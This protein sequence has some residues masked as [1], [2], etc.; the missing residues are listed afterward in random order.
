MKII[1]T[2]IFAFSIF[3]SPVATAQPHE[4]WK[5]CETAADCV[6][7]KA[8][9]GVTAVHKQYLKDAEIYWE[10]TAP[11]VECSAPTPNDLSI[12]KPSC[13]HQKTTCIK[14]SWFGFKKEIDHES[15]CVS[16]EKKCAVTQ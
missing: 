6:V 15:T 11:L 5:F 3:L 1:C 16:T 7:T 9:C 4:K 13:E 14:E 12:F 2:T 10:E 8:P